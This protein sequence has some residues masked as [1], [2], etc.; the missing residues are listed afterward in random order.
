MKEWW[1]W[2]KT[3]GFVRV[4]RA[5]LRRVGDHPKPHCPISLSVSL[6]LFSVD[7]RM[8]IIATENTY[9]LNPKLTYSLG[10]SLGKFRPV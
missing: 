7:L 10:C 1:K 4:F 9:L 8:R 6:N 3:N 2:G 5:E